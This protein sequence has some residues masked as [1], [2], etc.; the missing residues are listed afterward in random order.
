M[1]EKLLINN[2]R[3][4]EAEWFASMTQKDFPAE[5]KRECATVKKSAQINSAAASI[6]LGK[7]K[8]AIA[9]A[10]KVRCC[11]LDW[12]RPACFCK[13]DPMRGTSKARV[14]MCWSVSKGYGVLF[15]EITC[16]CFV[17]RCLN[18]TLPMSRPSTEERRLTWACRSLWRLRLTLRQPCRYDDNMQLLALWYLCRASL[19]D[20]HL[21]KM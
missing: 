16:S 21:S 9:A 2:D 14:H 11:C 10:N 5:V 18:L 19:P 3:N 6:K 4:V 1:C 17:C 20:N 12:L 13:G 7:W 8:D 15:D